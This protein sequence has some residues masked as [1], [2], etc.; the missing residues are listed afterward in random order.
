MVM[1]KPRNVRNDKSVRWV[2][3]CHPLPVHSAL[4]SSINI[5]NLLQTLTLNLVLF[6]A[7][8]SGLAVLKHSTYLRLLQTRVSSQQY[9]MPVK[10]SP[11]LKPKSYIVGAVHHWIRTKEAVKYRRT[12]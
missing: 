7:S 2:T 4:L 6:I 9:I 12:F 8:N 5:D 1:L 3:I 11:S 10:H